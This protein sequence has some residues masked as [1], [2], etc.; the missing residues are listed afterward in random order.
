MY[1]NY[2]QMLQEPFKITP[3]PRFLYLS[4]SH[5]EALAS[6]IYGIERKKG[7]ILITGEVGTGK[8][9]IVRTFLE[10]IKDKKIRPVYIFNSNI[11]FLEL[12]KTIFQELEIERRNDDPYEMV[13]LLHQALIEFYKDGYTI[14]L[15]IDEAQNMPI[16]TLEN[17]RM[18]TN[19][20]TSQEKL[21]QIVLIGQP[22]IQSK[23]NLEELRQLNQRISIRSII[24]PLSKKESYAYILHRISQ[25]SLNTKKIFTNGAMRKIVNQSQG[26]PRVINILCDN[27]LIA[28]FGFQKNPVPA[29]IAKQICAD[30]SCVQGS[31]WKLQGWKWAAASILVLLLTVSVL[32]K[33][34]LLEQFKSLQFA[35]TSVTGNAIADPDLDRQE[36]RIEPDSR[37]QSSGMNRSA[38]IDDPQEIENNA[39]SNPS[40][41]VASGEVETGRIYSGNVDSYFEWNKPLI[42]ESEMADF[43]LV[44]TFEGLK[45]NLFGAEQPKAV[46]STEPANSKERQGQS[47]TESIDRPAVTQDNVSQP[48][49]AGEPA[50][51]R[52][53]VTERLPG[54]KVEESI[55][56]VQFPIVRVIKEGDTLINLC[57]EVYGFSSEECLRRVL[58]VNPSIQNTNLI[59]VGETIV[60]PSVENR[61][62]NRAVDG[63]AE[64]ESKLTSNIKS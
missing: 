54:V 5:K 23:L 17:M 29:S 49:D 16:D 31:G 13:G 42:H 33:N 48:N 27:A 15:V 58:E 51:R 59:M 44:P 30:Y 3:D 56:S 10:R 38:S 4:P 18:L 43:L 55:E 20:E 24:K 36:T 45:Q 12:L 22:E 2:Y 21:L 57:R 1:L 25:A 7:I 14:V 11:S 9:T 39:A 40:T 50:N 60:F 19:L 61:A 37:D 6:I 53:I 47:E 64:K 35:N 52:A 32:N 34:A 46:E 63:M 41:A 8:T 26:I 28:G 62:V